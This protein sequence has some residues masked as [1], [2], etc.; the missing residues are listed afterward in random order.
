MD[1]RAASHVA[2][3]PSRALEAAR[4]LADLADVHELSVKQ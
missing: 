2:R 4:A 3:S 1:A